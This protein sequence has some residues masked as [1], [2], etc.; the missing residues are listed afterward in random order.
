MPKIIQ[1]RGEE[2][3]Q[4]GKKR[5]KLKEGTLSLISFSN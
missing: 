5:F 2:E 4:K 3:T 1:N